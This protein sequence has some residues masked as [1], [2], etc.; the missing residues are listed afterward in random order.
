MK[1]ATIVLSTLLLLAGC[2]AAPTR[3]PIVSSPTVPVATTTH[4]AAENESLAANIDAFISQPRFAHADFGIAVSSLDSGRTLYA[5]NAQ[6][7]FVPASNAKLYTAA[8][9]LDTFGAGARFATTLYATTTPR[10]DGVLEGNLILY[11]G[12]DPSLGDPQVF[13]D[14]ANRLAS[15]LRSRG[16]RR[17]HGDLIA[18]DTY[19]AGPPFGNGWEAGDLQSWFA[20][21]V[22]ALSV[23]GNV[24]RVQVTRNGARCC[25]VTLADSDAGLRIVNL[26]DGASTNGNGLSLYRAPGSNVLDATGALPDGTQSKSYALAVP[27]PALF[28]GNQLR[29][30]LALAGIAIDG[31]VRAIHW[32]QQGAALASSNLT[33]IAELTSPP[34]SR[35][36]QHMLKHSDNLYAQMLLEQV[37][38]SSARSGACSDRVEPPQSSEQWGLCAMRA[39]LSHAGIAQSGATFEEG[40]GLSRKDLVSPQATARLLAWIARQTF[41]DVLRNALPIAGVD[42][43]LAHRMIGTPAANN[44]RAKTGTLT[45]ACTLSGFV[46]DAR[47]EHL[48]FSLMLDHYQRPADRYG[49]A[50]APSP[51]SDLDAIA[52]MLAE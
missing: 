12:G 19:F 34:L 46:T 3:A 18:D 30:A 15:A 29:D 11:G 52:T 13:P 4:T 41:A 44:L 23:Q 51:T 43:T 26:T 35:L 24:T 1:R 32:P 22:S 14:W 39:M 21:P 17:V 2:A 38:V 8:L 42:G 45:H 9:A 10:S 16:V 5:H 37:G 25:D 20:M 31:Q 48:I 49:R 6:K 28:A 50:V 7:L 27:D 33:T 40:A 47:G 36:I